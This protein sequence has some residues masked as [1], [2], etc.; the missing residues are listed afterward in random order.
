[1]LAF[2]MF[3]LGSFAFFDF[4]YGKLFANTL[5]ILLAATSMFAFGLAAAVIVGN[6][7]SALSARWAAGI[8]S[9]MNSCSA[10]ITEWS[11]C[12][13]PKMLCVSVI[14]TAALSLF[15]ELVLIR[16][17]AGIFAV[18]ALYKNFTLLSCFCG[19]GIG[20]AKARDRQLTLP[21]SL[22]MIVVLL[23]TFS[24]LRYGIGDLGDTL[25]Q[26]VPVREE[27][28]V[29]FTFDPKAS[30]AA[31][32][33]HSLPVY[34]LLALT[35]VLNTLVL[36]P[37]GQFCGH[38]MQ[39]MP[40]LASYGYNLL[41]SIAGVS[42]LFALSWVWAGPVL[43][44][45]LT[46]AGLAFFQLISR[47][48]RKAA[49]RLCH[50]QCHTLAAWPITPLIQTIYSP[51]QVIERA[52][53]PNGLMTLLVSGSYYQKVYNLSIANTN[54]GTDETLQRIIGYYEL[55]FKTAKSVNQVAIVGAGS[56][57]D[58]KL[59]HCATRPAMSMRSR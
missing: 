41:G 31:Y 6:R 59:R 52:S 19:L 30:F 22:P 32:F 26:V 17:E 3:L 23:L 29:F 15:L 9:W 37:V 7:I 5:A 16:W 2:V 42:L 55:P 18:F 49:L 33:A 56:G 45:G 47:S 46:A 11:D 51:Y 53:Q 27:A 57:N 58:V 35:F 28:S 13:Q 36:L 44:F 48:A 54:R 8:E 4:V 12:A 40:P 20:Y 14:V 1:M 39:R 50:R 10:E 21:A 24:L 34:C 43:W 25:F 38:L